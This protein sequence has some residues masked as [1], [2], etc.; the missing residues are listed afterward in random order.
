MEEHQTD[1]LH[2]EHH[3]TVQDTV[4]GV[5][6]IQAKTTDNV[7]KQNEEHRCCQQKSHPKSILDIYESTEKSEQYFR[8]DGCQT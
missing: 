6:F 7:L 1:N 2:Y 4:E 8:N 3:N 5:F